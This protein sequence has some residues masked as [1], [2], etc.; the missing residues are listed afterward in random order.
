[1]TREVVSRRGGTSKNELAWCA[2]IVDGS[3]H[4]VP[5]RRRGLPFIYKA[6]SLAVKDE[7]RRNICN[8]AQLRLN[9]Q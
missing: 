5:D 8:I 9:I 2:P 7:L 1:M 3:P 6:R 4:M